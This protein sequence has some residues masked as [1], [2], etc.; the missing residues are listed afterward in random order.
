MRQSDEVSIARHGNGGAAAAAKSSGRL[1]LKNGSTGRSANGTVTSRCR[2]VHRSTLRMPSTRCG[3]SEC[4]RL[5]PATH[6]FKY[7]LFYGR[8]G[9]VIVLF[10]NERGKGDH[11]HIGDVESACRFE[12]PERLI[13]DFKAA[14]QAAGKAGR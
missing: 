13:E 3:S 10:D 4:R 9:E 14:V 1:T 8:P 12:S 2:A 6:E 5:L 11:K 7:S